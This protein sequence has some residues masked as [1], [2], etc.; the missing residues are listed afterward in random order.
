MHDPTDTTTNNNDNDKDFQ[1]GYI[2]SNAE[3]EED[4]VAAIE[5]DNE[6]E[7]HQGSAMWN[8][9][10]HILLECAFEGID[11]DEED[12]D[13][14]DMDEGDKDKDIEDAIDEDED[15]FSQ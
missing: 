15:T 12:G 7:F 11:L 3:E 9:Y 13:E 2:G 14:E 8:D 5:E 6:L 4:N 1:G 10:Q